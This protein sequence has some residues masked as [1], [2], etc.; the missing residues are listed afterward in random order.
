VPPPQ[1]VELLVIVAEPAEEKLKVIL[2]QPVVANDP[3][4]NSVVLTGEVTFKTAP[5]DSVTFQ[6]V[7]IVPPQKPKH[8]ELIG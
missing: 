7:L 1:P 4:E 5:P 8:R 2:V 3:L 6:V